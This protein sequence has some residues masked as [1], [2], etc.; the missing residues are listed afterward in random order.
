MVP[1]YYVSKMRDIMTEPRSQK[2][3]MRDNSSI[4]A[5]ITSGSIFEKPE[6]LLCLSGFGCSHYNFLELAKD[7][8][9]HYQMVL[10]DNRGMG[11]SD[12]AKEEYLL[13]DLAKD[14][15]EVMDQLGVESFHL[16]GTSMGGFV[17]Q[18]VALNA[19]ARVKSLSLLCTTSGGDR[20]IPL[21]EL[22][23]QSLE[24]FYQIPEPKRTGVAI[25]ATVYPG[26]K[27]ESPEDFERICTLRRAHPVRVDQVLRQKRAVDKFLNE[28]ILVENIHCPTFILSGDSDRFVSP[29]NSKTL[30][31][32]IP[33]SSLFFIEKSDHLFFLEKPKEVAAIM[34]SCLESLSLSQNSGASL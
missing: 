6:T 24:L 13:E 3:S 20:Y 27:E 18:L 34:K 5:L 23:E 31:S 9:H 10:I 14:A 28:V 29:K 11:L 1:N 32:K 12:D 21:P 8:G 22:T 4:H 25:E 15:L 2:F 30:N 33:N 7:L 17:S 16:A 19:P 26:L